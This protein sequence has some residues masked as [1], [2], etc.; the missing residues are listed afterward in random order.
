MLLVS[1][2]KSS[3]S[4]VY[5]VKLHKKFIFEKRTEMR[6]FGNADRIVIK[7]GTSTLSKEGGIDTEYI[8]QTA[9]QVSGLL[10]EGRQVVIVTSGAIG[11]GAGQ[12][13]IKERITI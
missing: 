3:V 4:M 5:F 7:I 8:S 10:K 11:M 13:N 9:R 2:F 12:L 1:S 6:N